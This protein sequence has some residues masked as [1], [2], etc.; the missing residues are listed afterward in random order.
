MG[1]GPANGSKP[2]E[3]LPDAD[4]LTGAEWVHVVQDGSSRKVPSSS[5]GGG[6]GAYHYG[7]FAV[8]SIGS[9]EILMDHIVAT[10]HTLSVD[11]AGCVASVGTP[12]AAP[13]TATI[14]HTPAAGAAA[15][16][17]TFTIDGAGL[18]AWSVTAEI[19]IAAG[20]VVSVIAPVDV[21]ASIARLR[22]TLRGVI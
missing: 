1:S 8:D 13:W 10:A 4:P 15:E 2:V 9:S 18:V 3:L 21:D 7:S 17:G 22:F 12:P 11:F 16:I 14:F 6:G 20:D 5:L 19:P